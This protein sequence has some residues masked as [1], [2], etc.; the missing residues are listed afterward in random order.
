MN[1][2]SCLA[3]YNLYIRIGDIGVHYHIQ[4]RGKLEGVQPNEQVLNQYLE[5]DINFNADL[6]IAVNRRIRNAWCSFRKYTLGLYNRPS[7]PL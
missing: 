6:S 2:T 4:R 1:N 7:A 3:K 5:R